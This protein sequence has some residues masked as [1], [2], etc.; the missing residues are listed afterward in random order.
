M[1]DFERHVM[2]ALSVL[3]EEVGDHAGWIVGTHQLHLATTNA[4][5]LVAEV[6]LLDVLH[7]FGEGHRIM[8]QIQC[9]WFPLIDRNPQTY[10]DNIFLADESDFASAT[11]RV[12]RTDEHATRLRVGVLPAEGNDSN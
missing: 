10:V 4:K 7:T 2:K 5:R 8:V 9:S 3:H 1:L 12:Y 6:E 11:Q